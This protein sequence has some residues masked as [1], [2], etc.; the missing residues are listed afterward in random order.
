MDLS[1][2]FLF[3]NTLWILDVPLAILNSFSMMELSSFLRGSTSVLSQ[4]VRNSKQILDVVVGNQ[5]ML[6][7]PS[8]TLGIRCR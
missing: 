6:V 4:W 7:I 8:H 5:V 2:Q 3:E 1:F